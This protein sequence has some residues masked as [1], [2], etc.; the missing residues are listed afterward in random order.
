MTIPVSFASSII[1]ATVGPSGTASAVA[2]C[3][4]FCSLQK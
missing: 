3:S 2:K 4:F 1:F